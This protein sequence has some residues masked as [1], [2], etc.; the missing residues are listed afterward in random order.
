MEGS[1]REMAHGERIGL[2]D[3]ALKRS[4]T[5]WSPKS[6]VQQTKGHGMT[7]TRTSG[8][9]CNGF[10]RS[11]VESLVKGDLLG[12]FHLLSIQQV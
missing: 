4:W 10:R 9:L 8:R 11:P 5:A 12:I 6:R 3:E 1:G 7:S 2:S